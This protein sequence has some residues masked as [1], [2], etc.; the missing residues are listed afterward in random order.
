M[1]VESLAAALLIGLIIGAQREAAGG[2]EHPGLRDFLL[3]ALAGGVC[4]LLENLWLDAAALLAISGTFAVF[5]FENRRKRTGITT[6]L[7]AIATFVLALFAAAPR[8]NGAE[9]IGRPLAIGTTLLIAVFLEARQRLHN[10]LRRVITEQEFNATLWFIAVVAVIYPLLPAGFYGPYQFF[11]PQQVWRFV[12]LISSISY[13]GY[14]L[15]KFLGEERGL[16]YTSIVGGLAS[17][18]AATLE[19]ARRSRE[20]PDETPGLWRAF[21]VAN[22]V[23]FPRTALIVGAANLDLLRATAAPL[24]AM[25]VCGIALEQFLSRRPQKPVAK[26][27]IQP[28]NPLRIGPALRFGLLFTAVV[29]VSKWATAKLGTD[30]FLGTSLIGGLV[31]V[32][33]VIAPAADL[34]RAHR[35]MLDTAA[36]GVLLALAANAILKTALAA[37]SGTR[38]FVLR[39]AGSF[40]LW[41]AVGAG[42]WWAQKTFLKV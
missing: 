6:E 14:F 41:A 8:F 28:G 1:A 27:T 2:E 4:G 15:E 24:A 11:S 40:L 34:L 5:H 18:T 38:G 39:I 7:A 19:F 33:T 32:A 10:L 21:V 3:V 25:L 12:M 36:I 16:F 9:A 29:F 17:T 20:N 31:D 35:L 23:Q 42:A 22:T 26:V 30:A 37:L 13:L